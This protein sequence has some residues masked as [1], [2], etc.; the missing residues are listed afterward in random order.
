MG[1]FQRIVKKSAPSYAKKHGVSEK[2]AERIV[3]GGI[4]NRSREAVAHGSKNKN[5][6]KVRDAKRGK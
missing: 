2:T 1:K 4:A 6:R 5:L 3:A